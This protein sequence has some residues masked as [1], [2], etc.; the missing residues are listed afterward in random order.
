MSEQEKQLE[1]K[2]EKAPKAAKP[3]KKNGNKIGRWFKEMKSELKKVQWPTKSQTL[4]NVLTVIVCVIVVGAFIWI[5]DGLARLIVEAL[6]D[7]AG[8]V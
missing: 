8:K 2:A 4:N 7:L 6:L 1:T 5:F 3:A